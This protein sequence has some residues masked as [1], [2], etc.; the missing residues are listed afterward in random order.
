[1]LEE[2]KLV[3][4]QETEVAEVIEHIK[5]KYQKDFSD[6]VD[7]LAKIAPVQSSARDGL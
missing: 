3:L 1:M 7:V 6:I 2:R 4:H 5:E